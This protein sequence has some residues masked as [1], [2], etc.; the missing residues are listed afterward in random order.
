MSFRDIPNISGRYVKDK[1][2]TEYLLSKSEFIHEICKGMGFRQCRQTM[3]PFHV[4]LDSDGKPIMLATTE[5]VKDYAKT[6]DRVQ[7]A[8]NYYDNLR[9]ELF[10][11]IL[12]V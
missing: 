8:Y 11:E 12:K 2:L 7:L 5:Q 9:E 4:V 1:I 3:W 10:D 6:K